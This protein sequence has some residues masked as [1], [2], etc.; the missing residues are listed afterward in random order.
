MLDETAVVA[1]NREIAES[2][3][4]LTLRAPRIVESGVSPGQFVNVAAGDASRLLRRPVSVMAVDRAN[5]VLDLAIMRVGEGTRA[6]CS[7]PC[8]SAVQ[9]LGPLGRPFTLG[10]AKRVYCVGGGMGVAPVRFAAGAFIAEGCD[11]TAFYGFKSSAYIFGLKGLACRAHLTTDDGSMGRRGP[12]TE[13]LTDAIGQAR[14]DLII[15]CGPEAMLRAV[16]DI[17]IRDRIPCQISLEARMAC[18]VGACLVCACKAGAS[19]NAY[20]RV[21]ADGP[22]FDIGEVNIDE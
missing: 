8:G 1:A 4:L 21:C 18:G 7:M 19:G 16:K 14:P 13:A 22:V 17:A 3:S 12:I 11:V 5:G 6:I 10:G 2:T 15:A 20:R 9:L